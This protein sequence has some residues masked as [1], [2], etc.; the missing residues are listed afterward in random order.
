M[1]TYDL[2]LPL[3]LVYSLGEVTYLTCALILYE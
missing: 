1:N 3:P 2:I